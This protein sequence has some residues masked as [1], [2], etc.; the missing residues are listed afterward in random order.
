MA[1]VFKLNPIRS[2]LLTSHWL[3]RRC[4]R[5]FFDAGP[6]GLSANPNSHL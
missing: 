5:A 6:A 2:S 4:D 1:L 3:I